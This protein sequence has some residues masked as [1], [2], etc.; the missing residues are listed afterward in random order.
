MS[1]YEIPYGQMVGGQELERL[2]GHL[3]ITRDDLKPVVV[4]PNDEMVAW[5][6][7]FGRRLKVLGESLADRG[8]DDGQL[9]AK[10]YERAEHII[11]ERISGEWKDAADVTGGGGAVYEHFLVM[12]YASLCID[13]TVYALEFAHAYERG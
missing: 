4:L 11:T 3:G 2:M 7:E 1:D 12:D 9:V 13:L 5:V 6:K 10:F 8:L